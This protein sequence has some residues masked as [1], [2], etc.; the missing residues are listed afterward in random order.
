MDDEFIVDEESKGH[1][2]TF[3]YFFKNIYFF[4]KKNQIFILK[5]HN[6][7]FSQNVNG[8]LEIAKRGTKLG[9]LNRANDIWR[10][11]LNNRK[12]WGTKIKQLKIGGQSKIIVKPA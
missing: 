2:L 7:V 6:I 3:I 1:V 10:A 11:K 8:S 4:V 12:T 5:C 9:D